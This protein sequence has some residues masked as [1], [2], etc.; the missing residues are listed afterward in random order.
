MATSNNFNDTNNANKRPEDINSF[1]DESA[2]SGFKFK[3]LVFLIL[4]NLHWFVI[5]ALIGGVIAYYKVSLQERIYSSNATLLIKTSLTSSGSESLRGS[6]TLGSIAGG[7]IV[8]TINNEIMVLKSQSLMESM[9]RELN[10]NVFYSYK[11]KVSKRNKDP[12]DGRTS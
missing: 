12:W 11:T 9:V 4:R 6:A 5:C 2:N 10:L 8:S 1:F 3:D 7:P